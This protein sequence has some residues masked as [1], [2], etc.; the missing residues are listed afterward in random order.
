[1]LKKDL[2]KQKYLQSAGIY[3]QK[4]FHLK[5]YKKTCIFAEYQR[6][7]KKKITLLLTENFL[8]CEIHVISKFSTS[9]YLT[10]NVLI[11]Y[12]F[13]SNFVNTEFP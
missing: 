4:N 10:E 8:F 13:G 7:E 11:V 3:F 12:E 6:L 5:H 1:M 9:V 2:T